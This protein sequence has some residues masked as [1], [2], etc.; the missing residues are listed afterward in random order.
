MDTSYHYYEYEVNG[1]GLPPCGPAVPACR[2]QARWLLFAPLPQHVMTWAARSVLLLAAVVLLDGHSLRSTARHTCPRGLTGPTC[3]ELAW[4]S[5][6]VEGV[7]IDCRSPAPCA[8]FAECDADF[9][10]DLSLP[11]C[12]DTRVHPF[13]FAEMLSAQMVTYSRDGLGGRIETGPTV[14]WSH[15]DEC[16]ALDKC[17]GRGLCDGNKVRSL[18]RPGACRSYDSA[19]TQ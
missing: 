9:M 16:A 7:R 15:P 8:C 6:V 17:N 13:T 3:A 14:R 18:L 4:P 5:C 10:L 11:A 12:Y 19:L 2:G 1:A